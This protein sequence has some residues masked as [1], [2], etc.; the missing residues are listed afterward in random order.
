MAAGDLDHDGWRG[1]VTIR[2]FTNFNRPDAEPTKL[3]DYYRGGE[4]Y[5]VNGFMF[6]DGNTVTFWW[7]THRPPSPGAQVGQRFVVFFC[8]NDLRTLPESPNTVVSHTVS[9]S[10]GVPSRTRR[11][12]SSTYGV[13]GWIIRLGREP[14]EVLRISSVDPLEGRYERRGVTYDIVGNVDPETPH[15]IRF[16]VPFDPV[17]HTTFELFDQTARTASCRVLPAFLGEVRRTG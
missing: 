3:G 10:R 8:E 5:D 16:K 4:R 2:R 13:G 15:N 7:L 12:L 11:S 9:G 6:R 17:D 14:S 1:E